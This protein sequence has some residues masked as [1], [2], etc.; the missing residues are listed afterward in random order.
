MENQLQKAFEVDKFVS[1]AFFIMISY[2]CILFYIAKNICARIQSMDYL[3]LIKVDVDENDNRQYLSEGEQVTI[4]I[5]LPKNLR[6]A[7]KKYADLQGSNFSA[8]GSAGLIEQLIV[9]GGLNE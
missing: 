2:E 6:N 7:A 5:R 9:K 1:R 4:T 8:L 3:E